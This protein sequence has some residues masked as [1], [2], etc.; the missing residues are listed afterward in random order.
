MEIQR[1]MVSDLGYERVDTILTAQ[2]F[3]TI[4]MRTVSW[5]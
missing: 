2:V 3:F 4:F 1:A 5:A